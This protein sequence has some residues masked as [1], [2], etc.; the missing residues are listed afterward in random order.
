M[1]EVFRFRVHRG[2]GVRDDVRGAR[3]GGEIHVQ[4]IENNGRRGRR[5]RCRV[6][7]SRPRPADAIGRLPVQ[8]RQRPEQLSEPERRW[9]AQDE[10]E[11]VGAQPGGGRGR[12]EPRVGGRRTVG[13]RQAAPAAQARCAR[14]VVD[15][16]PGVAQSAHAA[17]AGHVDGHAGLQPAVLAAPITSQQFWPVDVQQQQLQQRLWQFQ[18]QQRQQARRRRRYRRR[19]QR[20]DQRPD[21]DFVQ[22][23]SG[24]DGA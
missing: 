10:Q 18:L 7:S 16:R 14:A 9:T 20:V 23:I 8:G 13:R 1:T 4:P 6:G 22:G 21:E 11:P 5:R 2:G 17:P 12:V 15:R 3:S 24:I 19:Q